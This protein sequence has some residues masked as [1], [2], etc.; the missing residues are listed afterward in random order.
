MIDKLTSMATTCDTV[1]LSPRKKQRAKSSSEFK[2]WEISVVAFLRRLFDEIPEEFLDGL[3]K[4]VK[5]CTK[6]LDGMLDNLTAESLSKNT[7][8]MGLVSCFWPYTKDV[9][10]VK[11]TEAVVSDIVSKNHEEKELTLLCKLLARLDMMKMELSGQK[12]DKRTV[13]DLAE[14]AVSSDRTDSLCQSVLRMFTQFPPYCDCIYSDVFNNAIETGLFGMNISGR[15]F[16]KEKI[17]SILSKVVKTVQ[18]Q[19][20]VLDLVKIWMT[21]SCRGDEMFE[22]WVKRMESGLRVKSLNL[23]PVAELYLRKTR[24]PGEWYTL[25][26]FMF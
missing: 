10:M 11:I 6:E 16:E 17:K 1:K 15:D 8:L 3:K 23:C 5:T 22:T 9:H 26:D 20:G 24:E 2:P 18:R 13:K 19:H 14:L 21:H 12:L 4:I 25:E 7:L